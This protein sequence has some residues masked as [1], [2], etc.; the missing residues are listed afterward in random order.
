VPIVEIYTRMFCG[1]CHRAKQLLDEKGVAYKEFD[2]TSSPELRDEARRRSGGGR[3]VPQIFIDGE[4]IGGSDE[5]AA[6]E[7]SG[8]LDR[9]LGLAA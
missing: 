3:T 7:A 2:T 9:R 5:L 1:Y 8:E 4:P 6:L